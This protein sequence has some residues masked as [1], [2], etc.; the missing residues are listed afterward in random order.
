MISQLRPLNLGEILD[1]T[2]QLYRRNFWVFAGVSAAPTGV[3]VGLSAVFGAVVAATAITRHG[4]G[5]LG[6]VTGLIAV[7][8]LAL[9]PL[10]VAAMV[11]SQAGLT[12]AAL[13]AHN[14]QTFRIRDALGGVRPR[15]WRFLWLL[16]LQGLLAAGIPGVIAASAIAGLAALSRLAGGGAGASAGLGFP[17]FLIVAAA[18]VIAVWR[19]LGYAMGLAAC[20]VE[21]KTAW[22][23]VERAVKLSEKARGRIFV[24]FLLVWALSMLLSM[25]VY[26][27]VAIMAAIMGALGHGAQ[28]A[29]VVLI[30]AESLNVLGNF[31]L[32]TLIAPVYVIALLL[33]YFDQRVRTEGYDIERMMEEAG[34][35]RWS[36]AEAAP[37]LHNGDAPSAP[38]MA[39]DTV[40]EL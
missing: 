6:A 20:V 11:F 28:Y 36:G 3:M 26:I 24:M 39:P 22:E 18:I 40:K 35:S 2:A 8:L 31:A 29:A 30:L 12:R 16:V 5:R 1:R 32:Q 38:V 25:V 34:L 23:S 10:L 27:P 15:F 21:E 33:F 37:G 13:S 9:A 7:L 14:G 17:I 19:A 4:T